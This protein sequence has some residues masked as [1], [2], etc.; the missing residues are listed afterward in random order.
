MIKKY[1]QGTFQK[2]AEKKLEMK[3]SDNLGRSLAVSRER[4]W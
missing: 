2:E 3:L 4:R 1:L